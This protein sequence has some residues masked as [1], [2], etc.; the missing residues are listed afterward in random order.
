MYE[1]IFKLN[2]KA[3]A[4]IEDAKQEIKKREQEMKLLPLSGIS[5]EKIF[6]VATEELMNKVQNIQLIYKKVSKRN[7]AKDI[8]LL[9]AYHSATIEGAR[10][11]VE[12]VKNSFSKPKTKDDKMVINTVK[13]CDYAY[14]NFI[15]ETSIRALWEIV[16]NDV[17]ENVSKSGTLYRDGTVFIGS[18][19]KIIYVPAQPE[20]LPDMMS[21]LFS[22]LKNDELDVI[23]K[24]FV[25]HF[26]FVYLHPFCDG[27]G[28]TARIWTASYLY[29]NG[30]EKMMYLPLS[31][32]IN[33]NLSGYYGNLA[34]SE[35]KYEQ[36]GQVYLD[37]TP[38]V[39]YM[40]EMLGKCIIT[41]I[42]EENELDEAQKL[43]LTKM[44]KRGSGAEITVKNAQKILSETEEQT[45]KILE[46]LVEMGYLYKTVRDTVEVYILR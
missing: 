31:R 14:R 5:K 37:I 23:L 42:L 26:Y 34:D 15:D 16:V 12:S 24:A 7:K 1:P 2:I 40:L 13:G 3:D 17:C 30:Y 10:T 27:N 11:T 38:F 46:T 8:I 43:L 22:F 39:F 41:S 44:K 25:M 28:R 33:E 36:N 21:Q 19:S 29:H 9:D 18:E 45:V 32:T 6:L 4:G 35:W 20:Q